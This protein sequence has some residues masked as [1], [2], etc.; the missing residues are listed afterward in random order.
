MGPKRNQVSYIK[1]NEPAFL[2]RLKQEAGYRD[3]PD[4]DTK[5]ETYVDNSEDDE[6]PEEKEDEKPIVVVLRT[7]DLTA[8][9]AEKE[10]VELKREEEKEL[11]EKGKITFKPQKKRTN[12]SNLH[13]DNDLSNSK[14]TKKEDSVPSE[15]KESVQ[16]S[17]KK[18]SLLSF[19][20]EEED[21]EQ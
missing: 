19:C 21:E 12:T 10:E 2:R 3:G 5:R 15:K 6:Y 13:S 17:A 4:I 18:S 1:P 20:D 14:K 8:E 9:E 7:G 16:S 11:I